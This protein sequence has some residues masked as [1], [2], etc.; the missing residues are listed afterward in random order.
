MLLIGALFVDARI[1]SVVFTFSV[2]RS[3]IQLAVPTAERDPG[4]SDWHCGGSFDFLP[5]ASGLP[6]A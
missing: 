4:R 1:V 2:V 3:G 6:E 5:A